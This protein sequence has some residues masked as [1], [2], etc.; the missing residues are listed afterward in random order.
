MTIAAV[1]KKDDQSIFI[2]DFRVTERTNAGV[3]T[4][5]D[6]SF[7]FVSIDNRIGF[8]LAGDVEKW[9]LA[10]DQIE[11]IKSNITFDNITKDE[12]NPL[13]ECL[14]NIAL[15]VNGSEF[16]AIGFIINDETKENKVFEIQVMPG[17]GCSIANI[18]SEVVVIGSGQNLPNIQNRITNRI[19]NDFRYYGNDLYQ[20]GCS[21]RDEIK[22]TL[23]ECGSKVFEKLG[24][25]P[26]MSISTLSASHF[27]VRG[28]EIDGEKIDKNQY[29]SFDYSFEKDE[30]GNIILNNKIQRK[31]QQLKDI[32][33]SQ[34]NGQGTIFDPEM[35]GCS[36][37]SSIL[38]SNE[39]SVFVFHQWLLPEYKTVYRSIYKI[40]FIGNNRLCSRGN[41]ITN[42]VENIS[43]EELVKYTDC[44]DVYVEFKENKKEYFENDLTEIN[45]FDHEW[46]DNHIS[47]Y[48]E[49][50]Y[51][52][53]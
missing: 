35:L 23:N 43:D 33:S 20:L 36:E 31:T 26:V 50:F 6:I 19:E 46:L 48:Y 1:Y 39:E 10:L 12:D 2:S 16:C 53:C 32:K 45:L 7:K 42:I 17:I 5:K 27:L 41:S 14:I 13:R 4:Q 51:S 24:I 34:L 52:N 40:S 22:K 28:E 37:D 30:N 8:F 3:R 21:M 38:F 9:K 11:G 18:H 25:S 49:I 15:K 29:A 44:R 47:N